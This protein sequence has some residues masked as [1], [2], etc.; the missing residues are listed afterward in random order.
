MTL[1]KNVRWLKT[2]SGE[3]ENTG[4]DKNTEVWQPPH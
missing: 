1:K 3:D 4:K 2:T